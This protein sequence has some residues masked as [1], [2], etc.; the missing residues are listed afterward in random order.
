MLGMLFQKDIHFLPFL[1]RKIFF[2][3]VTGEGFEG[4]IRLVE[5]G[6]RRV[7]LEDSKEAKGTVLGCPD[8][9]S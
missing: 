8:T 3:V 4:C 2:S 1:I 7:K 5:I 6:S 9:V